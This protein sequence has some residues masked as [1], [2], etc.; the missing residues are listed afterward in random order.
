M[1]CQHRSR[2]VL[3]RCFLR[4]EAL[5]AKNLPSTLTVTNPLDDGSQGSLR[6]EIA[7]AQPGDTVNF[8]AS[9]DG[10]RIVLQQGH[11]AVDRD[12]TITAADLP[13]GVTLDGND[14]SDVLLV[15]QGVTATL[16]GLTVTH[17][18]T[19]LDNTAGGITN[20]GTLRMDACRITGNSADVNNYTAGGLFND[21][22]TLF[23][24]ESLVAGN[25]PGLDAGVVNH[26]GELTATDATIS[27]N[28]GN[29]LSNDDGVLIIAGGLFAGNSGSGI[30][31]VVLMQGQATST[32]T[33]ITVIDNGDGGIFNQ[34]P[35][36]VTDSIIRHNTS[37]LGGGMYNT[38][39]PGDQSSHITIDHC[40]IMNNTS[41]GYG[42]GVASNARMT[43]VNSLIANNTAHF[44]GG[45]R[46]GI[47]GTLTL[48][49]TTIT[50]N[51]A[52]GSGAAGGGLSRDFS[53][54]IKIRNSTISGNTS[55]GDGGGI[56]LGGSFDPVSIVSSTIAFNSAGSGHQGGGIFF[57]PG[58]STSLALHNTIVADNAAE[59]GGVDV[60]G[61]MTSQGYNLIEDPRGAVITG[62]ETGNIYGQDPLLGPLQDNGG[63]TP[64]R[65][66][67]DGSP[68][69]GAG[70]PALAGTPDQRGVIRG[71]SVDIGAY[72]TDPG[73]SAQTRSVPV[74]FDHVASLVADL[75]EFFKQHPRFDWV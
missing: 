3:I 24:N 16:A 25:G 7:A 75:G 32:L 67:L 23:L 70:D 26:L 21:Q 65:A 8:D 49:G 6:Y 28:A 38:G 74:A 27:Q 4:I 36:T 43:I 15:D 68:A 44:G 31:S 13:D 35:M 19:S 9:L 66:L 45:V 20:R 61:P 56:Y 30:D 51:R 29:G 55:D 60:A 73:G 62:D 72:Q 47:Y 17:G 22:G 53:S 39:L 54:A 11:L 18:H 42:G 10:Q 64:T 2:A 48:E 5:E 33:G 1:L 50:G 37:V 57:A 71:P 40:V 58:A 46:T 63:P 52:V 12:L 34:G 41:T 69:K 59:G 14:A